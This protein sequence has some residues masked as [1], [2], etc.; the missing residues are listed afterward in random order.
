MPPRWL[1]IT[2]LVW[3]LVTLVLTLVVTLFRHKGMT[4]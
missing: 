4:P 2:V 3:V 1:M